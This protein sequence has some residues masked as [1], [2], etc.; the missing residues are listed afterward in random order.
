MIN[1]IEDKQSLK[2]RLIEHKCSNA[3]LH[4]SIKN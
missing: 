1:P 3:D 2:K 4:S